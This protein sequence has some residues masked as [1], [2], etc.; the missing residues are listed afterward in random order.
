VF[1]EQQKLELLMTLGQ[2]LVGMLFL[3]NME[4]AWWEAGALFGLWALQFALSPVPPGP[5]FWGYLA[6]HIHWWVTV[7]Y[8]LWFGAGVLSSI[9]KRRKPLAFIQFAAMWRRHV[10]SG[11]V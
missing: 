2:S 10:R 7:A 5:G 3:I 8:F 9:V 6:T 1:D 11:G 4:L